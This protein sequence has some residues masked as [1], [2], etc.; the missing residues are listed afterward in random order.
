MDE[1]NSYNLLKD[2]CLKEGAS[3]FG[4][5]EIDQ[6]KRDIH[7]S[8]NELRDMKYGIAVAVRLS[9]AVLDGIKDRPTLLYKWHYRQTNALLDR[10]AYLVAT[11]I[12]KMGSRALPI[13]ASQIIDWE[14]QRGHLSHRHLAQAAGLGWLGRNNLLVNEQYGS[15]IR[16]VTVLTNLP[17]KTDSRVDFGCNGCYACIEACPVQALGN[18]AADYNFQKCFDLLCQ[19]AKERGFGVRI[20]GV[21]VRACPGR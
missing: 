18:R 16:L 17:L 19:F 4:V 20:C 3:L 1:E 5:C 12:Q 8:P 9:R 10:I 7:L 21:C 6:F 15:Q 14:R 2:F 13:P 11:K